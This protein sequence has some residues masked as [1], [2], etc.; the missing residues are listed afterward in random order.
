ILSFASKNSEIP[1]I[2]KYSETKKLS[3]KCRRIYELE[4]AAGDIYALCSPCVRPCGT[5]MS[6]KVYFI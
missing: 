3:D 4:C 5:E 6:G 1:I 2:T